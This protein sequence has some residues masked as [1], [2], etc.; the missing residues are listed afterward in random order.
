MPTLI[1][2]LV[3]TVVVAV[4][5]WRF[6]LLLIHLPLKSYLTHSHLAAVR[7]RADE[8]DRFVKMAVILVMCVGLF[9]L[10]ELLD[11]LP[12]KADG[13]PMGNTDDDDCGAALLVESKEDGSN[14]KVDYRG[15]DSKWTSSMTISFQPW[16]ACFI[17]STLICNELW[18]QRG[19]AIKWRLL[20]QLI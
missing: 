10:A 19:T 3:L 8:T 5:V 9:A 7:S 12:A 2:S 13:C 11:S 6:I 17:A 14:C 4:V 20:L 16:P 1:I 18:T 15:Y